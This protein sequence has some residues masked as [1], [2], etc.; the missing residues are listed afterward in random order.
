MNWRGE[1]KLKIRVT[2]RLYLYPRPDSSLDNFLLPGFS[3]G[4]WKPASFMAT[5]QNIRN[6]WSLAIDAIAQ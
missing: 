5:R 2:R 3:S 1:Q 6:L 4:R